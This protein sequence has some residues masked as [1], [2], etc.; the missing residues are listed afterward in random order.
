MKHIV[1]ALRLTSGVTMMGL[2]AVLQT[3]IL[4]ALLPSRIARIR[5]CVVFERLVG[6]S[7][8]WLAG[9]RMT[10]RGR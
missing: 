10:V 8:G 7:C 3:L 6:Y 9:A 1:A 5:S 2:A 4:L